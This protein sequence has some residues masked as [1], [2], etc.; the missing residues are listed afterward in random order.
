MFQVKITQFVSPHPSYE[1]ITTLRICYQ[2]EENPNKWKKL[3]ALES[4]CEA[5]KNSPKLIADRKSIAEFLQRFYN[6]KED[7]SVDEILKICGLIEVNK[8]E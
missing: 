7:F 5:R 2:K 6:L 4:H 3:L 1:C 8:L